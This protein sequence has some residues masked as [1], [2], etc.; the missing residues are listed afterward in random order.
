MKIMII[1]LDGALLK[2]ENILAR[3]FSQAGDGGTHVNLARLRKHIGN[4]PEELIPKLLPQDA[5][6]D[7][8]RRSLPRRMIE[9]VREDGHLFPGAA[10]M[11]RELSGMGFDIYVSSF[12]SDEYIAA[13]LE[14]TGIGPWVTGFFSAGTPAEKEDL[15]R[16][17]ADP[18][19][20]TVVVGDRAN[21]FAAA[22]ACGMPS[23]AVTYGYGMKEDYDRA[24]FRAN[25][26]AEA[27]NRIV[28]MEVFHTM[29]DA[30]IRR[31]KSR[32]IGINGLD[33][34]GEPDF[35]GRFAR[36][37][38]SVGINSMVIHLSDYYNP[39]EK[40]LEGADKIHSY[41]FNAIN[42][43]KVVREVLEPLKQ[44]GSI[45]TTVACLD[46]ASDTYS[47]ER[48]YF[49]DR[50]TIIL[51]EGI[52]LFREP[53]LG[54]IDSRVFLDIDLNESVR[55][56]LDRE[57]FTYDGEVLQRYRGLLV[58]V[59]QMYLH[60]VWPRETSDIVVDNNDPERPRITSFEAKPQ[61]AGRGLLL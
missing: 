32:F 25:D 15:I 4:P 35:T 47:V 27:V 13:V 9:A 1:D 5:D 48:T 7:S 17:V 60:Q 16:K 30:L 61:L 24:T 39:F 55:R 56:G 23:V 40:Q 31:K 51:I 54:Y 45:R 58:P 34:A 43:W 29:A 12:G 38:R 22:S 42:Y 3:V 50:S 21:S 11:L 44:N 10:D 52:L 28:Q 8:F 59:Q 53:I 49:A 36:Y 37:L 26:P 41:Y 20:F 14:K 33:M 18:G 6:A 19:D 46:S 2:T 57:D